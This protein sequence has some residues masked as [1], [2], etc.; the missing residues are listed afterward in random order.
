MLPGAEGDESLVAGGC[1]V[2]A[3]ARVVRAVL[4]DDVEV[5]AGARVGGAGD[6]SLVGRR[7][8]VADGAHLPPG[9]R[10]RQH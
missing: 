3:C 7:T 5:G 4:D 8:R 1:S 6:V 9:S 2:A 10:A